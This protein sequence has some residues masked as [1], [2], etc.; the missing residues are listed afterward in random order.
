MIMID[1]DNFKNYNDTY[2]HLAGISVWKISL[3]KLKKTV[4]RP[5]DFVARFG[6]EEFAVVLPNTPL[7]V[8]TRLAEKIRKIIEE[9]N[10]DTDG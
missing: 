8:A 7:N 5:G 4:K 6:G 9:L 2:G 1:I 3:I 10:K